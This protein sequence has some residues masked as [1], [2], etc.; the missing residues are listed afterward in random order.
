M[1]RYLGAP[2]DHPREFSRQ[3]RYQRRKLAL[4][5]CSIC[6]QRPVWKGQRCQSCYRYRSVKDGPPLYE[7]DP[8]AIPS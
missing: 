1:Q 4:G 3:Y 8:F 5:L 2:L 7:S 6:G